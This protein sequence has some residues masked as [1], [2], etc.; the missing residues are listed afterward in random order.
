MT[1]STRFAP[2][3]L[4]AGLLAAGALLTG[5]AQA[6]TPSSFAESRGYQGCVDAAEAQAKIIK[7]DGDYFIREQADSRRIYLNGYAFRHGDSA[8]VKI[9]CET[10][11]SGARV[12]DVAVDLGRYAGR[13]VEP[14]NVAQN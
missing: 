3:G 14:V 8:P 13:I 1:H 10:T 6:A 12:L 4:T 11:L 5:A 7:V 9:S 2:S